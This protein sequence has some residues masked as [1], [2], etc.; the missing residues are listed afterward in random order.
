MSA[1]SYVKQHPYMAAGAVFVTGVVVVLALRKPTPAIVQ[2]QVAPIGYDPGYNAAVVGA[3]ASIMSAQIAANSYAQE[4][5]ARLAMK[6]DDNATAESIAQIAATVAMNSTNV[7]GTLASQMVA[8]DFTLAMHQSNLNAFENLHGINVQRDTTLALA[9]IDAGVLNNSI[10]A[11]VHN[12]NQSLAVGLERSRIEAQHDI[13]VAGFG[14]DIALQAGA[15][16]DKAN[17]RAIS[18]A[19]YQASLQDVQQGRAIEL[20]R[21][22]V[23]YKDQEHERALRYD[24]ASLDRQLTSDVLINESNNARMLQARQIQL[25]GD[26]KL[27]VDAN[28]TEVALEQDRNRTARKIAKYQENRVLKGEIVKEAGSLFKAGIGMFK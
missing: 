7:E 25:D 18:L 16:A 26:L 8:G 11:D 4:T 10:A 20:E 17:E 27:Q 19:G 2:Q 22:R 5:Q 6:M 23:G 15:N 24:Y 21:M 13:T 14:R 3:N 12:R 28:Q 1:I 9:N